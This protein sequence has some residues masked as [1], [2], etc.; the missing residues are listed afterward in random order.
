MLISIPEGK[1]VFLVADCRLVGWKKKSQSLFRL[2]F[3]LIYLCLLPVHAFMKWCANHQSNC[4][5]PALSLRKRYSLSQ[6]LLQLAS[7]DSSGYLSCISRNWFE[8]SLGGDVM[9]VCHLHCIMLMSFPNGPWAKL[10]C[11]SVPS[12]QKYRLQNDMYCTTTV[13]NITVLR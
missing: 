1:S 6:E 12:K 4:F 13:S 9:C 5:K 7:I 11:H 2:D 3:Y 10:N 8:R